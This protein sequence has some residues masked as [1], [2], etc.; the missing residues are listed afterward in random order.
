[1]RDELDVVVV[2]GG[3]VGLS[4]AAALGR[5]GFQLALLE[6][7]LPPALP[8]ENA[9]DARVY[10]L[11]PGA[12][13]F[14]GETGA[15]ERLTPARVARI[16]AMRIFGDDGHS[17]LEF[18]A[19]EAGLRQLAFV[20]ESSQLLAALWEIVRARARVYCPRDWSALEFGVHAARLVLDDGAELAARL[21]VG[22]DGAH[23]R[24][25]ARAGIAAESRPY[26]QLGVVANFACGRP[27]RGVAFQWFR[28]D[29]VLALLP[30]PGERVSMVWSVEEL[31]GRTLVQLPA[32]ALA[33]EVEQAS[34]R[35]LGELEPVTEA[36]AYPLQWLRVAHLVRPR[37][38][39]VGD[40]AHAVHPLAGQ[41]AN[42][43]LRDARALAAVLAE[44]G[45]GRDCGDHALL[46]RYER[47]RREDVAAVAFITDALQ[48]L[49]H[50][51]APG[52]ATLRNL[53]LRLADGLPLLKS[54]LVARAVA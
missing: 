39:L 21:V 33:L 50:N 34:A 52:L 8:A 9:W 31:R 3:L 43:G 5:A 48:R 20:V 12:A 6:A 54:F 49:F 25:R 15:W 40:A 19:Y 36:A 10:A 2:G 29:G 4:L 7:T 22:A 18:S 17:R 32:R 27:H 13:A 11:S 46:R 14:L 35:V 24:V 28:R 45:L 41:G 23:S 42:L 47:A 16:E 37:L 30:L 44:R 26:G 1:M 53:G 38:A 51:D